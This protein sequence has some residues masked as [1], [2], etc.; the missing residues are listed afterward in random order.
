MSMQAPRVMNG[1]WG[2]VWR[3]GELIAEVNA[4]QVKVANQYD[5]LDICGQM[6]EDR[7]LTGVKI[8]GSMTLHK[9]Y[10]RFSDN[11]RGTM[12]GHDV[13]DTLVGKLGDPDAYG[14]ERITVYDVSYDEQTV[15]D[16]AAKKAGS[17]TVPFQATGVEWND[18][19]NT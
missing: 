11:V 6:A 3:N 9:V 15:M 4:F 13:R 16:W 12:A 2:Q 7:K 8:T 10:T 1:T 18:E 5:T 17:I 14:T 19:V